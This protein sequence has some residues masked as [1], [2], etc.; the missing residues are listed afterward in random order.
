[1]RTSAVLLTGDPGRPPKGHQL[2]GAE[3]ERRKE[4]GQA[5][6]KLRAEAQHLLNWFKEKY[7]DADPPS[8]LTIENRIRTR[9]NAGVPRK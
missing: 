7:P 9:F 8:V 4:A 1:M 3:F 5:L 2:Y 6:P